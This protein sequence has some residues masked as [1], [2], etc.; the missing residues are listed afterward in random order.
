[1]QREK[2]SISQKILKINQSRRETK[3]DPVQPISSYRRSTQ[4]D[5]STNSS[6]FNQS[7]SLLNKTNL[8]SGSSLNNYTSGIKRG[9]IL[10]II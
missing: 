9:N 7:N 3:T 10:M 1:M 2:E 4:N 5:Y 8:Y 6:H